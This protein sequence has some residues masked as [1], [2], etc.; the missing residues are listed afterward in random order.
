MYLNCELRCFVVNT[1]ICVTDYSKNVAGGFYVV[2]FNLKSQN[3]RLVD[4]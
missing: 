1:K 2:Y 4:G 3:A